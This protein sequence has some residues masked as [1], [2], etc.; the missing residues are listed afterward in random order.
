MKIMN[1]K[2][3]KKEYMK[4]LII[5]KIFKQIKKAILTKVEIKV[6]IIFLHKKM[7]EKK[8]KT[9]KKRAKNLKLEKYKQLIKIWISIK[10]KKINKLII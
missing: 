4:G 1:Q 10:N 8:V 7:K 5:L 3:L 9:Y 2:K 6:F